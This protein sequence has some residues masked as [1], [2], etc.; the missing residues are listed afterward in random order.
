MSGIKR[1]IYKE[2]ENIGSTPLMENREMISNVV[3]LDTNDL[4]ARIEKNLF[5]NYSY[6][7]LFSCLT[8]FMLSMTKLVAKYFQFQLTLGL[9]I[10]IYKFS[11]LHIKYFYKT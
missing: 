8:K 3:K 9:Y 11:Y 5:L 7:Y 10:V 1:V 6:F 2:N 4:N